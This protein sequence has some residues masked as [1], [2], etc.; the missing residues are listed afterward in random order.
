MK[1]V[2]IELPDF[3]DLDG[4]EAK[5]I[6]AAQLYKK[7]KLSLGQAATVAGLSKR[8]FF[9]ILG[10]YEVSVFNMRGQELEEDSKN[11]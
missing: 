3:V 10:R 8:T 7:G 6:L 5:N 9:E 2:N 11:A 1:T 4:S